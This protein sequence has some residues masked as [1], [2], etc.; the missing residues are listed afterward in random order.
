MGNEAKEGKHARRI[1]RIVDQMGVVR[2][3]EAKAEMEERNGEMYL[4]LDLS[5]QGLKAEILNSHLEVKATG[6][7]NFDRDLP[8]YRTSGGAHVSGLRATVPSMMFAE[9]LDLLLTQMKNKGF[10]FGKVAG[11]SVSGQQHGSVWWENGSEK[12]LTSLDASKGSLKDQLHGC[13]SLKEGPIWMDSSTAKECEHMRN[14]LG[15]DRK[16]LNLSG[17]RPYERFTGNQIRK[18]YLTQREAYDRTERISLV[19]SMVTSLLIGRY[20]PIDASDASGMNLM[21]I[22]A[23]CW[24]WELLQTVVHNDSKNAKNVLNPKRLGSEAEKLWRK[25]GG[26][27][28]VV[29]SYSICGDVAQYFVEKYQFSPACKIVAGSGDNPSSLVGLRGTAPGDVI[30]SLGT[31]DTLFAVTENASMKGLDGHVLINPLDDSTYIKMLC[32]KNGSLTRE[33]VRAKFTDGT[34]ESFSNALKTTAPGN[35]GYIGI[36]FLD[37]EIVPTFNAQR[38]F[39]FSPSNQPVREFPRP[40]H[41]IRALLEGHFLSMRVHTMGMRLPK[42]NKVIATGG[43]SQNS[44]ILQIIADV[45]KAPVYVHKDGSGS[46]ALGAALRVIHALACSNLKSF[47]TLDD[48]LKAYGCK[49]RESFFK[50]A[51][52]PRNTYVY[53]HMIKKYEDLERAVVLVGLYNERNSGL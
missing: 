25:L 17:S 11:I 34:W 14:A 36:Y 35:E 47:V 22:R 18:V 15:G 20:A 51:A 9:A 26:K 21:N 46:A 4:G 10:D 43:A 23:K 33:R 29:P 50:K 49:P 31:S 16:V 13:F 3:K 30:I 19:S 24:S 52:H 5:T 8:H 38:V 6:T 44:D 1:K 7:I 42:L 41:E 27:R 39:R 48:A 45:F 32:F 28:G 12:V 40:E 37:P 2:T 53:D